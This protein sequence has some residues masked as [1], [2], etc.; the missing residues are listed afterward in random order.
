M[1]LVECSA[2]VCNARG[3]KDELI[4]KLGD[5]AAFTAG[6]PPMS[7]LLALPPGVVGVGYGVRETS[8]ARAL[9]EPALR[10]YVK[11]KIPRSRLT[12][13]EAVP[14]CVNGIGTDVIEI[15]DIAVLHRP[16][17]CGVS[18]GHYATTVGTIGCMV[19]QAAVDREARFIL[20]NNHVLANVN[21]AEIGDFILEPGPADGGTSPI[22]RLSDYEPIDFSGSNDVDAAIA[23]LIEPGDVLPQI[24]V[25][26]SVQRP[27]QHAAIHDRVR[28]HG[29]TTLHTAG[30]VVDV[31]ADIRVRYGS[32]TALFNDQIGI[33]GVDGI[34]ALEGDSGALIV[35][36]VTCRPLA[37]LFAGGTQTAFGNPIGPVLARFDVEI[38]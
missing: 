23:E 15:G 20:S 5:C 22:A 7:R 10:V 11:E 18:C 36:A 3:Y 25:I 30:V 4:A 8:S 12:L 13:A 19:R 27:P 34:F 29:R 31:A 17:P 14:T 16:T 32:R 28:K 21:E 26:G 38:V 33:D 2:V 6:G 9:G 37:L 24:A 35:E 1:S